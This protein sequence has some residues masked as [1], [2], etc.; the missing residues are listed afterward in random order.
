MWVI[1]SM[2][3]DAWLY[4]LLIPGALLAIAGCLAYGAIFQLVCWTWNR[5]H[6]VTAPAPSIVEQEPDRATTY[7]T[8]PAGPYTSPATYEETGPSL[9]PPEQLLPPDAVPHPNLLRAT[10]IGLGA[11]C[12]WILAYSIVVAPALLFFTSLVPLAIVFVI[13]ALL[14]G[15]AAAIVA[16]AHLL[17]TTYW[18]AAILCFLYAI[19]LAVAGLLLSVVPVVLVTVIDLVRW[20]RSA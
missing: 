19:Y 14:T 6:G 2:T 5:F 18:R 1:M 4:L 10:I 9:V 8:T 7:V 13:C 16:V 20:L 15:T 3:S 12:F 17:P 11:I